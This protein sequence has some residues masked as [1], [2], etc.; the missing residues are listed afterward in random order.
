[1][2]AQ[3]LVLAQGWV[4]GY[5]SARMLVRSLEWARVQALARIPVPAVLPRRTRLTLRLRRTPRLRS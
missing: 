4:P 5:S 1:M 3:A 2:P